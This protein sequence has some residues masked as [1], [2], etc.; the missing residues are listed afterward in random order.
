MIAPSHVSSSDQ[1][2]VHGALGE[3]VAKGYVMGTHRS[4]A[5][6]ETLARVSPLL[7]ALG[8]TRVANITGL[9]RIGIPVV[10]ACRPNSRSL[11]VSQGKGLDL[12]AAKASAVM[13]SIE[14]YH[15]ERISLPLKLGSYE[16][17]R[18]T[19]RLVELAGLP[20]LSGSRYHPALPLLWIEGYDLMQAEPVWLPYELVHTRYTLPELP[21]AGCFYPSSNGLASGNHLLE[22]ISHGICEVVER[23]A[24]TLWYLR[25]EPA[26]QASRLDLATVD[27]PDCRAVLERYQRAG[28]AVAVWETTSDVGLPGF[29]CI[30]AEPT[31][32]PLHALHTGA[33][34]GC[35]PTR[36]V[37]LLR[38]L[39]EA[40]QSRLTVV[41]GS[42]DDL[43]RRDYE[44]SGNQDTLR[45]HRALFNSG[46]S[47]RAFGDA[48]SYESDT[49]NADLNWELERL[50]GAG[51]E[52][53][54]VVDLTVREL[55]VPV[56]RVV[57]P[58]LEPLRT[59]SGYTPGPRARSVRGAH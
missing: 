5:P 8:I 56:T 15:A 55:R 46:D 10:V 22:A 36:G 3:S 37:A 42:R 24:T 39:T 57:I 47:V 9:D 4:R 34:A 51:I 43:F 48:P 53:V 44:L 26:Q 35:H 16:E 54:V 7:P 25:P 33:G 50:R 23:D 58:G 14:A 28:I 19:H 38:A 45:N 49:F 12:A 17:L 1:A 27:D 59:A 41:A 6:A 2:S 30:I 31:E 21:G 13:E 32:D 29:L 52:R 11:A 40:A 20:R 18:Y